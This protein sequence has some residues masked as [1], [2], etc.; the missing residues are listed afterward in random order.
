MRIQGT[1]HCSWGCTCLFESRLV[2]R[3]EV[4]A[5]CGG[6]GGRGGAGVRDVRASAAAPPTAIPG[7]REMAAKL[8]LCNQKGAKGGR[9]VPSERR[10]SGAFPGGT[11]A[12]RKQGK[13]NVAQPQFCS[14]NRGGE[15]AP[16]TWGGGWPKKGRW[17]HRLRAGFGQGFIRAPL[18]RENANP[19]N[20]SSRKGGAAAKI[21]AATASQRAVFG[22]KNPSRCRARHWSRFTTAVP[23]KLSTKI[24]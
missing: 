9:G 4:A 17:L 16:G 15:Q 8:R 23:L 5:G 14:Q 19:Q 21:V 24:F 22:Q 20:V 12:S 10:L 7:T 6:R 13:R 11:H 2:L 1:G 18:S 3:R